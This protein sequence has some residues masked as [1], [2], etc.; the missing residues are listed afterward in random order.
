LKNVLKNLGISFAHMFVF[1]VLQIIMSMVFMIVGCINELTKHS[2]AIEQ[3]IN[4]NSDN[5][6]NELTNITNEILMSPNVLSMVIYALLFSSILNILYFVII[7]KFK[8]ENPIKKVSISDNVKYLGFGVLFNLMISFILNAI[9]GI[10]PSSANLELESMTNMIMSGNFIV[11]LLSVGILGP[12]VEELVFRYGIFKQ[13]EK[14]NYIFA[15]IISSLLFGIMHMNLVQ[16]TYATLLGILFAFVYH[17]TNNL[18]YPI[19]LHIGI[20]SSSVIASK[21]FS[22]DWVG[23]GVCVSV[24]LIALLVVALFNIKNKNKE[25]KDN[26]IK[27][28]KLKEDI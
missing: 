26:N 8:K 16:S 24:S 17:K 25:I 19:L 18:M 14:I 13:L 22:S 20:N 3:V 21:L 1:F 5:V 7:F 10:I 4:N 27:I 6:I 2:T 9:S 23:L 12:I 28:K 11:V 15:I